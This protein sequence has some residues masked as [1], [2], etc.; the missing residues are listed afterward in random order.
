MP[1]IITAP[2]GAICVLHLYA[3]LS[4]PGSLG[5]TDG[6]FND[7]NPGN[8]TTRSKVWGVTA[9][10]VT[11]YSVGDHTLVVIATQNNNVYGC[12]NPVSIQVNF[13]LPTGSSIV[14]GTAIAAFGRNKNKTGNATHASPFKGS[15]GNVGTLFPATVAASGTSVIIPIGNPALFSGV[16]GNKDNYSFIVA[17][18]LTLSNGQAYGVGHDPEMEVNM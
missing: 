7:D 6:R 15:A 16:A 9:A 18:Q 11:T 13:N 3:D 4:S 5:V 14:S 8:T 17:I 2:P 10:G 1:N 12:N